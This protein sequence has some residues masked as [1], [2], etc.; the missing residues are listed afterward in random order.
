MAQGNQQYQYVFRCVTFNH[1]PSNEEME[2]EI[3]EWDNLQSPDGFQRVYQDITERMAMLVYRR[4]TPNQTKK[5]DFP[6][7][8]CKTKSKPNDLI[9]L[10]INEGF[11][12]EVQGGGGYKTITPSPMRLTRFFNS[13]DELLW[14]LI[15]YFQAT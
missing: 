7:F 4:E 2:K 14:Y 1:K 5:S 15:G 12:I 11:T 13:E 8:C 6:D 9:A 3:A 10:A